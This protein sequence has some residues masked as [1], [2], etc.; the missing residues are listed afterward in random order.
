[1]DDLRNMVKK[2][3]KR[4]GLSFEPSAIEYLHFRYGGH[5]LLTRIAC[6]LVHANESRLGTRR[7][8]T[9]DKAQLVAGQLRRDSELL[10]YCEHVISELRQFYGDEY[11]MLELLA[12]RQYREFSELARDGMI[13]NHL[14]DYGLIADS[15]GIPR[16]SIP[17]IEAYVADHGKGRYIVP[18]IE[19]Q[20]WVKQRTKHLL[21][22]IRLLESKIKS[23]KSPLLY[24]AGSFPEADRVA[25]MAPVS[26]RQEFNSFINILYRSFIEPIEV[27]G[28]STGN[29][30]YF[31][32]LADIYIDIY[33]PFD[34]VKVYRNNSAHISLHAN[35]EEKLKK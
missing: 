17:A 22:D 23:S 31:W 33:P 16:V 1:L 24:G 8:I 7:P 28:N 35:V 6:S 10:F 13:I 32:S 19:R 12:Q 20:A 9:L 11:A 30:N 29:K 3:G 25:D 27:Y 4:M 2:L 18:A 34:K 15:N 26:W 5:P 14:R 21:N